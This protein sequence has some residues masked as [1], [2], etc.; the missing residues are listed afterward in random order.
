M[1][2]ANISLMLALAASFVYLSLPIVILFGFFLPTEAMVNKLLMQFVNVI[3]RT[4]VIHGIVA[5]FM[6]I[7]M[8]SALSGTLM[9]YLGLV[10]VGLVGGWWMMRLATAT[11]KESMNQSMG[12]VG[13]V[14]MGTS[15]G[16]LGQ[17]AGNAAATAMG[18]AK[19]VGA[20]ALLAG[21]GAMNLLDIGEASYEAGRSGEKDLRRGAAGAMGHLDKQLGQMPPA[22][23]RLAQSGNGE[24]EKENGGQKST[25][26]EALLLDKMVSAPLAMLG[27][28]GDEHELAKQD[29]A[30]LADTPISGRN[31]R[32]AGK[33]AGLAGTSANGRKGKVNGKQAARWGTAGLAAAAMSGGATGSK[34]QGKI[35]NWVEQ[36][37]QAQRFQR[38]QKQAGQAGRDL[39]G[40]EL[41]WK[42]E[43]A[44]ARRSPAETKAVL[45]ATR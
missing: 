10:G 22:L 12:A 1:I 28:A 14:W 23:A 43:R 20:G 31:D 33:R 26:G 11:M 21:G 17:S 35:D 29:R 15:T 7:L 41:A 25:K 37:Y 34:R 5:V 3:L 40:E 42:A 27:L 24:A 44:M 16:L 36:S 13:S 38:G 18:A 45:E 39:V 19:F 32:V 30:G 2:E 8:D 9:S 6:L 4:L